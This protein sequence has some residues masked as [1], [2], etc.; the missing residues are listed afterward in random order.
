LVH[1]NTT[2]PAAK[3]TPIPVSTP[4]K[5]VVALPDHVLAKKSKALVKR[6]TSTSLASSKPYQPSK[7]KRLKN[8]SSEARSSALVLE[9]TIDSEDTDILDFCT[10]LENSLEGNEGTSLRAAFAP[11]L[12]IRSPTCWP[13]VTTSDPSHVGTSGTACASTSGLGLVRK[14]WGISYALPDI[15]L[16]FFPLAP[17]P[18][19][20]PYPFEGDSSPKYTQQQRALDRTIILVKLKRTKSLPS[21]DLLNRMNVLTALLASHELHFEISTLEEKYDKLADA[22]F[23]TARSSDELALTD[24]KLSDQA[25]VVRDLHNELALE[26]SKS[27]EY[28]DATADVKDRLNSLRGEVTDFIGSGFESLVRRLLSSNEFYF[29]LACIA[30]LGITFGVKRGLRM[31]HID[32]GFAKAAK[33][34][35]NY[36]VGAEAEFNKA[37]ADLPSIKFPFLAK[38][39]ENANLSST[40]G[41]FPP[42]PLDTTHA[43]FMTRINKLLTMRQ[44]I[45]SLL[46][47]TINEMTNQSFDS[48]IF[49]PEERIKELELRTQRRNNFE[50]ELFRNSF[51]TEKELAYHKELLAEAQPPFSTLKPKI[52]RGDP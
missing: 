13:Y 49:Y 17:G 44:T 3:V 7:K 39:A 24:A 14:G 11:S 34:V 51:P 31:G 8:K 15:D 41:S 45:D 5:V 10:D 27:Q 21:L 9:Q 37:V 16:T 32:A 40:L 35:S 48:E 38:I 2:T 26:R 22:E 52:R 36:V 50:E 4:N 12:Q 28:R 33:N 29:S 19:F 42:E 1:N 18:Y 23:A 25:L 46:F 20:M 43:K 30:Y 47:K 6:N